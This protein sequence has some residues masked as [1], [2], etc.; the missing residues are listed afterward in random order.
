MPLL[1]GYAVEFQCL[2]QILIDFHA[3][4]V[5]VRELLEFVQCEGMSL[6]HSLDVP[7]ARRF[8]VRS[9]LRVLIRQTEFVLAL[10]ESLLCCLQIPNQSLILIP[11]DPFA[12]REQHT[13]TAL[14]R[15]IPC[16]AAFRNHATAGL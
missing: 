16:S 11:I 2:G 9:P 3:L 6:R 1:G 13:E 10:G 5:S 8:E 7:L 14:G 12:V 4:L 15:S